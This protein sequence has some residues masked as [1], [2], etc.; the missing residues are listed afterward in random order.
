MTSFSNISGAGFASVRMGKKNYIG[1][2]TVRFRTIFFFFFK[3]L[4]IYLT[5]RGLSC[6]TQDLRSL[7]RQ[8]ESSSLTWDRIHA[9]CM[10]SMET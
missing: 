9:P 10:G 1:Q 7:F 3:Y 4:F 6:S 5:A 2:S 8:V